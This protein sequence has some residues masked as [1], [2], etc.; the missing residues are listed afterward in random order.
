MPTVRTWL[1]LAAVALALASWAQGPRPPGPAGPRGPGP[2]P[3]PQRP[4]DPKVDELTNLIWRQRDRVRLDGRR[5]VFLRTPQG[6]HRVQERVIRRGQDVRTEFLTGPLAGQ[7]AIDNGRFRVLFRPGSR[8]V[9]MSPSMAED[10]VE[11]TM[12]MMRVPGRFRVEVSPGGT[13]AGQRTVVLEMFARHAQTPSVKSWVEP[14]HGV[15]LKR[16]MYDPAGVVWSS[17]EFTQV[18]LRPTIADRAFETGIADPEYI[19]PV[20]D[21]RR[22]ARSLEL[23]AAHLPPE[24]GF[25]LNH[26]GPMRSGPG[27]G[28]I[29]RQTYL[30]ERGLLSLFIVDGTVNPDRLRR[31]AG[32]R[33]KHHVW[34]WKGVTLVLMGDLSPDELRRLAR[35]VAE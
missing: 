12:R 9:R 22:L 20:E 21:L 5:E 29:I 8:Q 18:N 32:G 2:G 6:I 14:T 35:Q 3:G 31:L 25:V 23:P 10:H 7:I 4:I 13:V 34:A 28:A 11:R 27:Q 1:A 16:E 17:F 33:A 30:G 26:V 19:T 24:S 15:V